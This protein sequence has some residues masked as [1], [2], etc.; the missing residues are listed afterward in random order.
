MIESVGAGVE[1][2]ARID[3]QGIVAARQ[4]R[5]LA[6]VFHPELTEDVRL[7]RYFLDLIAAPIGSGRGAGPGAA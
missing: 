5:L 3:G 1:V 6:T 4:G 7:H 2:L